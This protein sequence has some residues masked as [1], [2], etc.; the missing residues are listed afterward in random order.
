MFA[1]EV[2]QAQWRYR[3]TAQYSHA[4][5]IKPPVSVGNA[6]VQLGSDGILTIRPGYAWDGPSGPTLDTPDFMR[7]SLV[8]D[9]LY[10]LMQSDKIPTSHRKQADQIFHAILVGDKMPHFRAWYAYA[11]VR[12]F[13]GIVLWF[14]R[15]AR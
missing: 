11:A 15:L 8:H 10:Q 6:Y 9:A 7:A 2:L 3:L 5:D 4:T 1:F 12:L 13:G 14:W